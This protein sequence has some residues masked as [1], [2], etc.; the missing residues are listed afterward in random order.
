MDV[1]CIECGQVVHVDEIEWDNET[2]SVCVAC[3]LAWTVLA[4]TTVTFRDLDEPLFDPPL[5]EE[6]PEVVERVLARTVQTVF[7]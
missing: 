3:F 5:P 7:P 6:F 2:G 4:R 1:H